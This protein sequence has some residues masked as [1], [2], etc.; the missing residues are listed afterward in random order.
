M[1][2]KG[3]TMIYNNGSRDTITTD[4]MVENELGDLWVIHVSKRNYFNPLSEVFSFSDNMFMTI[5]GRGI[6]FSNEIEPPC[7]K[8]PQSHDGLKYLRRCMN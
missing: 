5:G 6:D 1:I 2:F 7:G 3:F 8:R 4:D